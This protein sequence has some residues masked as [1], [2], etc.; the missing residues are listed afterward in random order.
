MKYF[1]SEIYRVLFVDILFCLRVPRSQE[2]KSTIF[3]YFTFGIYVIN[4]ILFEE[5]N[6]WKWDKYQQFQ[7]R[8]KFSF[9]YAIIYVKIQK[10]LA[11]S[12]TCFQDLGGILS[13]WYDLDVSILDMA[14]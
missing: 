11:D 2:I 1:L 3:S 6:I 8:W 9:H 7:V 10:Y 4:Q 12:N 14:V 5:V 13:F